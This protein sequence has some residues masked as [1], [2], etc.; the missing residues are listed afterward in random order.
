MTAPLE[1]IVECGAGRAV[2]TVRRACE[3]LAA[4]FRR[5]TLLRVNPREPEVPGPAS[6]PAECMS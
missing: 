4:R 3:A 5:A 6:G 2:P 1:P